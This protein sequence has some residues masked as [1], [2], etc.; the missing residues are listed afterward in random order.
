MLRDVILVSLLLLEMSVLSLC[1]AS[2]IYACAS[3]A[4]YVDVR[5]NFCCFHLANPVVGLKR[6]G[7]Q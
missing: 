3:C 2:E 1:A 4:E 5:I 6:F 7:Y